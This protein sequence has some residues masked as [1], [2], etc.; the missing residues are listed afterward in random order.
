[1]FVIGAEIFQQFHVHVLEIWMPRYCANPCNATSILQP[2]SNWI[3]REHFQETPEN[4]G[5]IVKTM[6]SYVAFPCFPLKLHPFETS[7]AVALAAHPVGS[8]VAS[9]SE[10]RGLLL[11]EAETGIPAVPRLRAERW[12]DVAV[13]GGFLFSDHGKNGGNMVEMMETWLNNVKHGKIS[14]FHGK[15]HGNHPQLESSPLTG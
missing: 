4:G 2:S 13:A 5:K 3:L 14:S 6:V 1:M 8:R 12:S 7:A 9:R 15:F 11:D 10:R